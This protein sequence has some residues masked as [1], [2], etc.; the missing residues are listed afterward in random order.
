MPRY[1]DLRHVAEYAPLFLT[2]TVRYGAMTL[3]GIALGVLVYARTGSP[4]LT[5]LSMFGPSFAQLLG[6]FTVLSLADRV[7]PRAALVTAALTY[8]AAAALAAVPGL[9]VAAILALVTASGLVGVVAGGVQW[10]LLAEILP[11]DRY[12]LG[13]SLFTMSNGVMQMLG[14]GVGGLLVAATSPRVALLLAAAVHAT[15]AGV[16]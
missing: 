9:P 3:Q 16:R 14:Y 13:R 15:A 6:A 1:R 4:L 7:P 11:A 8:A 2:M 10:G 12:V 5:A